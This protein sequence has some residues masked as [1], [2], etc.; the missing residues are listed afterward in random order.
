MGRKHSKNAGVMGSEAL[1]Y[2]EKKAL[3]YGTAQERLGKVS[4][5][6]GRRQLC[7]C[8]ASS[9]VPAVPSTHSHPHF[10]LLSAWLQDS[11]GNYYDCRL[12]LMPATVSPEAPAASTH[13][14]AGCLACDAPA[15]P[16]PA[17]PP[18]RSQPA[19]TCTLWIAFAS[20]INTHQ[21]PHA[22]AQIPSHPLLA[23]RCVP[24]YAPSHLPSLLS[25]AS[26]TL[27]ARPRATSSP[28]RLSW[29]TCWSRRRWVAHTAR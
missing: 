5:P 7:G 1:S 18:P 21:P 20:T 4:R 22:L 2:H 23:G 27:F 3:G 28:G 29:R 8:G 25:P 26:R 17:S 10:V 14:L 11:I 15:L 16:P 19:E 24:P 9:L 6:V 12:T 13:H